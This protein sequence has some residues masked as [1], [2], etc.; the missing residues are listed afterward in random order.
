M[1]PE[2]RCINASHSIATGGIGE[3]RRRSGA[4]R[5]R[6]SLARIS[7]TCTPT[8]SSIRNSGSRGRW[9]MRVGSSPAKRDMASTDSQYEIVMN[10]VSPSRS[11][12]NM[13][14]QRACSTRGGKPT[15][16]RQA[17]YSSAWPLVVRPRQ[18]R[19]MV[20]CVICKSLTWLMSNLLRP[21]DAHGRENRALG[22][23]SRRDWFRGPGLLAF[24]GASVTAPS[25]GRRPRDRARS[26]GAGRGQRC[27]ASS[28]P[29]PN[30]GSCR[31]AGRIARRTLPG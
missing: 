2:A 14:A 11:S 6:P 24:K 21:S 10:S 3:G 15:S 7:S 13:C 8:G 12:R 4:W 18:M 20:G 28:C 27:P 19:A 16:R 23:R 29:V 26:R 1:L 31:G 9:W 30:R 5:T 22:P 17:A 25:P